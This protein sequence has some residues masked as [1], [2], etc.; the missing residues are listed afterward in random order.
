MPQI[1]IASHDASRASLRLFVALALAVSL[2]RVG[3]IAHL[4]IGPYV[5]EAY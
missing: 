2:Y 3:V 5:D 4:E 1:P